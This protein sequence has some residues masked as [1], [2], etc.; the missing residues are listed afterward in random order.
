MI[1]NPHVDPK[2]MFHV[3]SCAELMKDIN[4]L[5]ESAREY[6]KDHEDIK[7]QPHTVELDWDFWTA[8]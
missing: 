6:L 2:G 8:G 3:S 7:L 1:M 4:T 5:S